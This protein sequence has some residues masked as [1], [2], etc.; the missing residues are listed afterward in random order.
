[1][2]EKL[3]AATPVSNTA[4]VSATDD[5]IVF[6][7]FISLSL[8]NAKKFLINLGRRCLDKCQFDNVLCLSE[9]TNFSRQVGGGELWVVV[10]MSKLSRVVV[11]RVG[12]VIIF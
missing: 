12:S 1:V 2:P 8:M 9:E 7:N 4:A 11:A 6:I 5:F 10:S 3:L